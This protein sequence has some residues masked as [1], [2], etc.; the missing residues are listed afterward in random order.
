MEPQPLTEIESSVHASP[1]V[2]INRAGVDE[3]T[4][5]PGI[6]ETLA[7]RIVAHREER[8]PFDRVED[9]QDVSGIGPSLLTRIAEQIS[10]RTDE[11]AFAYRAAVLDYTPPPLPELEDEEVPWEETPPPLPFDEDVFGPEPVLEIPSDEEPAEATPHQELPHEESPEEEMPVEELPIEEAPAE[12]L[13]VEEDGA[14]RRT[15]WVWPSL[16][17]ALL[18]AFLGLIFTLLLLA[19][20]NGSIDVGRSRAFRTLSS[21][22]DGLGVQVDALRDDVSALQSDLS[23]LRQ[24]VEVLS[25]LTA[26]MEAAEAT[27]ESSTS[28]IRTLERETGALKTSL[29]GLEQE[30]GALG[31]SVDNLEIQTEKTVSFFDRLRTALDEFFATPEG[32]DK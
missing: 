25:G 23:G 4:T 13:P 11:D 32:V 19:G 29:D 24:R 3:L 12:E 31:E 1:R 30:L 14:P 28:A 20:I 22:V 16:L 10:V 6:G 2:N 21:Q 17:G 18:G 26:R 27:L 8:G 15:S 7:G 5:L 9:L